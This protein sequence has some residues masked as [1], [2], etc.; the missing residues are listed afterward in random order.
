MG[1]GEV[2]LGFIGG[3]IVTY[4]AQN[5]IRII[6]EDVK[7]LNDHI[8]D[9]ETL[10]QSAIA[11]W[12]SSAKHLSHEDKCLR[13]RIYGALSVADCFR[14]SAERL[15]GCNGK[16]YFALDAELYDIAT[17]GDFETQS[18]KM[19]PDR[20]AEIIKVAHKMRSVLRRSRRSMYWFR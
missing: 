1:L 2:V 20:A 14:P 18:K 6:D 7:L 12:L 11:Y 10:E 5:Y 19:D 9:L 8:D 16:E 4:L 13:A 3:G 15:L 17:G